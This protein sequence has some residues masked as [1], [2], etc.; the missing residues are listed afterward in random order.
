[1]TRKQLRE[2]IFT[3]LFRLDFHTAEGMEEQIQYYLLE[4]TCTEDD[5]YEVVADAT[6]EELLYIRQKCESVIGQ[7]ACIDDMIEK[8]AEKWAIKRIPKA[9][10]TLMRLGVYELCYDDSIPDKVA[11]NEAVELAKK[12]GT[13]KT[14]GFINAVLGKIS[15]STEASRNETDIVGITD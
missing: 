6:E 12:Y 8:N 11:I 2:S 5:D 10:L 4:L 1:M 7:L 14:P 13:D 15:R 9:D 3:L